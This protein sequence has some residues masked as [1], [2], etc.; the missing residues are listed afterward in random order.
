MSKKL[1][2]I[3]L[4]LCV[5]MTA[6][7]FAA[8][9]AGTGT[10]E[11]TGEPAPAVEF[12]KDEPV[13][14][15]VGCWPVKES[16]PTEFE[17]F[18]KYK[19]DFEKLYPN[20]TVKTDEWA[21]TSD[22]FLPRAAAK[23][24][25]T[26]YR[27]P[28]TEPKK[29][30]NSGY[31]RDVTG[32]VEKYGINTGL[33]EESLDLVEKDGKYFGVPYTGYMIGMTYNGRLFEEAGLVDADGKPTYPQTWDEVAEMGKIIKEK[34]GAYGFSFATKDSWGGWQFLELAWAYG[35]EFEKQDAD[36]NWQV[37][38]NSPEMIEAMQY[39]SDLKWKY[40]IIPPN[41]LIDRDE[42][43]EIFG[44]KKLAM[45]EGGDAGSTPKMQGYGISKDD[46]GCGPIP[47]GPKGRFS[48]YGGDVYMFSNAATDNEIAAAFLW[49]DFI[50]NG[51]T[52]PEGYED[53]LRADLQAKLDD[54]YGIDVEHFLIWKEGEK[55][56]IRT[57]VYEEMRNVN[58]KYVSD[59]VPSDLNFMPEPPVEAQQLYA[60]I[61]NV[62]Q[63][64][65]NDKNADI[66]KLIE[67]C[68]NNFQ[69]D[70]LDPTNEENEDDE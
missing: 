58:E 56:D 41:I 33:R 62:M 1:K 65:W 6:S 42:R 25:P 16:N 50:G 57:R 7:L 22:T 66:P 37:A 64:V 21:F 28:Y 52:A 34:T 4:C 12:N 46:V 61:S 3:A 35:V 59:P 49:L 14:I 15:T 30:I 45:M 36:G 67:E 55:K 51:V 26:I 32:F 60:A 48:Q 69:T 17:I 24:L 10:N 9:G 29:I 44:K 8:C 27:V 5:A 11:T 43:D 20:V 18:E 54:G 39:F 19:A 68:A 53:K 23:N 31:A 70:Y 38:F 47:A 40:D 13:E 2:L 63:A